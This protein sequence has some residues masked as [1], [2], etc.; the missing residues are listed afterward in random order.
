M[1]NLGAIDQDGGEKH[2]FAFVDA[3]EGETND[4]GLFKLSGNRLTTNAELDYETSEHHTITVQVTDKD[5]LTFVQDLLIHVSNG[6]DAPTGATLNNNEVAENLP[7]DTEIGTLTASD[8]DRSDVHTFKITGGADKALFQI[9]GDKLLTS[10]SL[11]YEA[12]AEL[13]VIVRVTDDSGA[14]I[15]VTLNIAVTNVNDPP[16]DLILDNDTVAENEIVG[17]TVGVLSL[18]D[19]SNSEST[20]GSGDSEALN[21]DPSKVGTKLWEFEPTSPGYY[22]GNGETPAIGYDNSVYIGG[23]S[24]FWALKGETGEVNWELGWPFGRTTLWCSNYCF[25]WNSLFRWWGK[26]ILVPLAAKME[27]SSG[28]LMVLQLIHWP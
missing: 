8:P 6:N 16:T 12:K 9:Q 27:K 25:K 22:L 20:Q 1:G 10:A 21:I 24:G 14:Y 15:D 28:K 13:E 19:D 4:N 3:A 7:A 11:D 23:G 26:V 5:G 17:S 18:F 2:V